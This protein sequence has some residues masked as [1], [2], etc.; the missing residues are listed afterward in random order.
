[1][2]LFRKDEKARRINFNI[3]KQYVHSRVERL[4]NE[5]RRARNIGK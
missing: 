3:P 5:I 4:T 1:M 2:S